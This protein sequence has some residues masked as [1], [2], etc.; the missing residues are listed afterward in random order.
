[1][2]STA[3]LAEPFVDDWKR[4]DWSLR[5]QLG[6]DKVSYEDSI[7]PEFFALEREAYFRRRWLNVG[8]LC[9]LP[10]EGSFFT[11][12]IEVLGTSIIVARGRDGLVRAFHN[13]CPHRGNKIVWSEDPMRELS[14][15]CKLFRC[16]Y[17]GW[18][19]DLAG[20]NVGIPDEPAFF[21]IEKESQRLKP[22]HCDIWNSLIF[23]NFSES[24]KETLEES[25]GEIGAG[26]K[27]YPLDRLTFQMKY[28]GIVESNWKLMHDAFSEH[29]HAAHLHGGLRGD[30]RGGAAKNHLLHF[31]I[32]SRGNRVASLPRGSNDYMSPVQ[33]IFGGNVYGPVDAPDF[34][35]A[36][37]DD[38]PPKLN[39]SRDPHWG[40]DMFGFGNLHLQ[41]QQRNFVKTY[42]YWPLAYNRTRWEASVYFVPPETARQRLAQ[43][44]TR[45]TFKDFGLQDINLVSGTQQ[46]LE[47]RVRDR[48]TLSDE[49]VAVRHLHR[50]VQEAVEEYRTEMAKAR[51]EAR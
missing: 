4:S 44:M 37:M 46:M 3:S 9:D 15:K 36:T 34:G 12:E 26:V 43:E 30:L 21:D 31:E 18:T 29:Y 27:D 41:I 38:L 51:G 22:V 39:A 28:T 6:T 10:E 2:Q 1:M 25:M 42:R 7:S 5:Y 32:D 40:V 50:V 48:F 35:Y 49:E 23:V 14:G 45:I 8:H 33:R 20:N 17:H 24:P 19:F 11:K 13:S 16:K 47:S